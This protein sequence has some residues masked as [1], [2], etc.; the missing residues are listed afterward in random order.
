MGVSTMLKGH[1]L[2]RTLTVEQEDRVSG[3]SSLKKFQRGETVYKQDAPA[4]HIFM[5]IK[6]LVQLRLP[7]E[8]AEFSMIVSKVEPDY[9]FGLAP[10]MSGQRYT[11]TAQCVQDCEV[12]AIEAKPLQ[13]ILEEN[14][15]VGYLVMTAVARAYS[16]R[17]TEML[18]NLQGIMNH[19]PVMG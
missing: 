18:K 19:I 1:D 7:A 6:G 12:L 15:F 11:V 17:Y 16:E 4:T 10:L 5:L 8:S 3:F 14:P 2:F 9:L 13:A